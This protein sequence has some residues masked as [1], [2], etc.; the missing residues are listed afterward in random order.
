[1]VMHQPYNS[2]HLLKLWQKIYE[3]KLIIHPETEMIEEKT[4]ENKYPALEFNH[5]YKI[6]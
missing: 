5:I 3:K 1:M 6:L 2:A 4:F